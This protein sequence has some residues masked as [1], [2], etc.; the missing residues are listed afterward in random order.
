M[1]KEFAKVS[2]DG[3]NLIENCAVAG[4]PSIDP[5]ISGAASWLRSYLPNAEGRL[6]T[7]WSDGLGSSSVQS[8]TIGI[9]SRLDIVA[10]GQF[11]SSATGDLVVYDSLAGSMRVYYTGPDSTLTVYPAQSNFPRTITLIQVG[12]ID[13]D[14][15]DDLVTYN[16]VAG[17]L[18][19][20]RATG[21]GTFTALGNGLTGVGSN[22][23]NLV[24]A[25]FDT[26]SNLD[27]LLYSPGSGSGVVYEVSTA[28]VFSTM[29]SNTGWSKNW[30]II[31]PGDFSS[32]TPTDLL[33]Y[34]PATGI[35]RFYSTDGS[36]RTST[37]LREHSWSRD[38]EYI[39]GTSLGGTS[40]TDLFFYAP[41]SGLTK[42][43]S[44]DGLGG[45][46]QLRERTWKKTWTRIVP[47]HLGGTAHGDF[48]L[49]DPWTRP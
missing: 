30:E 38:W 32:G 23:K 40:Y 19:A 8:T 48:F 37:L 1:W 4:K 28:G 7:E 15:Y 26:D 13:T 36:G 17:K 46:T 44:T 14:A 45:I 25:K 27:V 9:S 47:A 22:G 5:I 3:E 42:T 10:S 39:L 18:Q 24:A 33:F 6:V 41:R 21:T 11:A 31:V 35:A 2:R 34:A 20:Y 43:F 12:K 16:P 29:R 49:Y